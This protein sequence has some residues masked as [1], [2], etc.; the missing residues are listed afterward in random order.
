MKC[1][2]KKDNSVVRVSE[3]VA[4]IMVKKGDWYVARNIWRKETRDKDKIDT[5]G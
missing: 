3:E 5:N 4:V 2:R 1:I